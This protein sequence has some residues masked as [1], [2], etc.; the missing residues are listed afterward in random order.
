MPI[1]KR[2]LEVVVT[3]MGKQVRAE[4]EKSISPEFVPLS[5]NQSDLD[6]SIFIPA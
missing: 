4:Q 3:S 5:Q 2:S 6:I 1:S